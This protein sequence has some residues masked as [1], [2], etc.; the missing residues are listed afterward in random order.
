VSGETPRFDGL[1][2]DQGRDASTYLRFSPG[3]RVSCVYSSGSPSQ[4]IVWLTPDNADCAQGTY[5]V[6]NG[7]IRYTLPMPNLGPTTFEGSL[8]DSNRGPVLSVLSPWAENYV[9]TALA[10]P[11]AAPTAPAPSG[12][13]RRSMVRFS[14]AGRDS[15]RLTA[16]PHIKEF[17]GEYWPVVSVSVSDG[18]QTVSADFPIGLAQALITE[19]QRIV[20]EYGDGEE[21]PRTWATPFSL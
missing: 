19:M 9:F 20:T 10:A 5:A 13:R 21:V 6:A 16:G 14:V 12:D 15:G 1:Y 11:S 4:V 18:A 2:M 8:V 17:D 3:N 7:R